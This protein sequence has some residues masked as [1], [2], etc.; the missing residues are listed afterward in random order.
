MSTRILLAVAARV[1]TQI[2]RDHRT[3]VMLLVLP[4]LLI[5]LLWWMFHELSEVTF[6]RLE[7]GRAS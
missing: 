6:D 7:I 4:C 5:S 3:L 1:L 2:R